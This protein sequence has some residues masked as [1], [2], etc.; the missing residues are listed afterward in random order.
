MLQ[1][2]EDWKLETY[3]DLNPALPPECPSNSHQ[4]SDGRFGAHLLRL[5]VNSASPEHVHV[6]PGHSIGGCR[7]RFNVIT[8]HNQVFSIYVKNPLNL[9]LRY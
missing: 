5:D 2:R 1:K 9:G 4:E 7:R 8:A 3:Q 6:L